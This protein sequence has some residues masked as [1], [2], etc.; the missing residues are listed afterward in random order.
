MSESEH[1]PGPWIDWETLEWIYEPSK[2]LTNT[3]DARLIAAAPAL[4]EA[5]KGAAAAIGD[6]SRPTGA[7]GMTSASLGHPLMVAQRVI[8]DAIAK[9]EGR[10]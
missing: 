4:L 1:T 7:N 8:Y 3:A 5:L 6:W 10:S 2:L 9:A